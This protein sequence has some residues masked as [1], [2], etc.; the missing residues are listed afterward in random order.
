MVDEMVNYTKELMKMWK[1]MATTQLQENSKKYIYQ[2]MKT[3]KSKKN[4]K[5]TSKMKRTKFHRKI[6]KSK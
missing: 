6:L 2:K 5:K 1:R 4:L 3:K